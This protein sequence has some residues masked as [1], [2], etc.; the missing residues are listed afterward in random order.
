MSK[1]SLYILLILIFLGLSKGFYPTSKGKPYVHN[2]FNFPNLI[3]GGP[4][5]LILEDTFEAGF[6]MKT[7]FQRY[8]LIHGFK[9]P[10]TLI[11]RASK[12]FYLKNK[13]NI[14]MSLFRRKNSTKT[15]GLTPMPPG[16]LYI[17][18]PTY[19][20]WRYANSGQ[21]FWRFH[22]AYR[23]YPELF[24]W[25]EWKPSF[26]F[27]T[28]AKIYERNESAFY[29]LNNEFGTSGSVT[30]TTYSNLSPTKGLEAINFKKHFIKYISLPTN[31]TSKGIKGE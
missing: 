25:G 18:D 8:K 7:Y 1:A 15:L 13:K 20:S 28:K 26:K 23:H 10:E 29:G 21:R 22:R 30:K 14:G 3:E 12:E 4:I 5:T 9:L 2:E 24:K 19:G 27:Y 17:G 11:V 16:I 31:H 6:L